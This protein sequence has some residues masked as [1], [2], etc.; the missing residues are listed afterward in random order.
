M[1][2]E[3]V[4]QLASDIFVSGL[5]LKIKEIKD[6]LVLDSLQLF[7][8]ESLHR[9]RLRG[10][11]G[12]IES[13][14]NREYG[15]SV[16]W[17]LKI[18]NLDRDEMKAFVSTVRLKLIETIKSELKPKYETVEEIR[19]AMEKFNIKPYQAVIKVEIYYEDEGVT[20]V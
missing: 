18:V 7:E 3:E 13:T 9:R 10:F 14:D 2:K 11:Y 20:S 1:N 5:Y 4:L 8:D 19:E 16:D 17:P 6:D 12:W 15:V